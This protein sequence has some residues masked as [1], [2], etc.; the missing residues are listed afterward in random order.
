[1]SQKTA[2]KLRQIFRRTLNQEVEKIATKEA[3]EFDKRAQEFKEKL[4]VVLKPAPVWIPDFI[5]VSLQ[6]LFLNI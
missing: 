6:K 3:E 1:M 2:K 4:D 5:W